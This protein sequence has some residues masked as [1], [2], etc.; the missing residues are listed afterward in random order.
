M[1]VF[2]EISNWVVYQASTLLS[3]QEN[4]VCEETYFSESGENYAMRFGC[5]YMSIGYPIF[6]EY[7]ITIEKKKH[8]KLFDSVLTKHTY[9]MF[10]KAMK[11]SYGNC[12]FQC[13]DYVKNLGYYSPPF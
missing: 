5:I 13:V 11:N 2:H 1:I 7:S 10:F 3:G 6:K 8:L 9:R 4:K 12:L